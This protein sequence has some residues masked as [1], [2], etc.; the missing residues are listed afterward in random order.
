MRRKSQW[1]RADF[2]GAWKLA[3]DRYLDPFLRLCFP[4]VHAGIDWSREHAALDQELQQVVRD[5]ETGKRRVDKLYRVYL[6]DGSE[7]WILVHVEVQ[8]RVD[9]RLPERLYRYYCRI[10]DCHRRRVVTLAVL[11]DTSHNFRPGAYEEETLGCRV[12]FE[13]PS[14]KLL[15]FT[16]AQLERED[17]RVAIVIA[18]HRAAQSQTR[19]PVLRKAMKWEV[20]RRLYER[21]YSKEDVLE[22]FRLIDW[23]I[24]LPEEQRVEFRREVIEYE[25]NKNMPYITSIEEMGR[26]EGRQE[27][28]R[29]G[30]ITTRQRAVL[31][32]LEIRFGE[33]PDSIRQSIEALHDEARLRSLLRI[34]I[35]APSLESFAGKLA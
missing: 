21:G 29:E 31:D 24:H 35:Q 15:D 13:Y 17:N 32:A 9:R 19:D 4:A 1:P 26:Q 6:R 8:G 34:A 28:L 22:L 30:V 27:G 2:D 16:D 3:L 11:A 23:F 12:R 5:A 7:E 33:V 10:V 14:C 20:T 25:A 18:A